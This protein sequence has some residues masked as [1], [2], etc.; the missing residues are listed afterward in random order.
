MTMPGRMTKF[1]ISELS[2]VTKPAQT[3]ARALIMKRDFTDDERK[4]AADKGFALPDGSYP[5]E[6]E[7]DLGNAIR[8]FGRAKD[9]AAT[10]AHIIT[11]AKALGATGQLPDGWLS[12]A[13][14]GAA[15]Q[16]DH[17]SAIIKKALG[18]AETATDEEVAAA[19]TKLSTTLA[20]VPTAIAK[21]ERTVRKAAM[22]ADEQAHCKGMDDDAADNFMKKPAAERMAAMKKALEGDESLT[23]HGQTI[24]KSGVGEAVFAIMKGQAEEIATQKA[25]FEKAEN[26]RKDVTFAKRADDEFKHLPG[27]VAERVMVLKALDG[28]DEKTKAAGEAILKAAEATAKLAFK[29]VG[30]GQGGDKEF[31]EGEGAESKLTKLAKA[32]QKESGGKI[33]IEKAYDEMLQA[34]PDLYEESIASK[35][36]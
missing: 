20:E 14:D 23:L 27:T 26:A 28:S 33:S 12:K 17:M 6:T 16:G 5:I 4:A 24:R 9:K 31:G 19:I 3:H 10:K 21:A 32:H 30:S 15:E 29:K 2:G 36:N 35:G 34:N 11:R 22:S 1:R 25:A 7:G 13:G 18:L 8:A